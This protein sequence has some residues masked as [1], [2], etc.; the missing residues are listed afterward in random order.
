M[1]DPITPIDLTQRPVT[2][3]DESLQPDQSLSPIEGE[4]R[5]EGGE[6]PILQPI[7]Q[8]QVSEQLQQ[9][10]DQ[11][12]MG[13]LQELAERIEA[14]LTEYLLN[15]QP[16][17]H[18]SVEGN[19]AELQ[20]GVQQHGAQLTAQG[21]ALQVTGPVEEALLDALSRL[22]ERQVPRFL[23]MLGDSNSSEGVERVLAGLFRQLTGAP[24]ARSETARQAAVL[25]RGRGEPRP[26]ASPP[27]R[28]PTQDRGMTGEEGVLYRRGDGGVTLDEDYGGHVRRAMHAARPLDTESSVSLRR[29]DAVTG[30][31]LQMAEQFARTVLAQNPLP[32]R[33]VLPYTSEERLGLELSLLWLEAETAAAQPGVSPQMALLLRQA[34]EQRTH[35]LLYEAG[36]AFQQAARAYPPAACPDLRL[37]D[38]LSVQGYL[39]RHYR[40][41]RDPERS[42]L[43]TI[44]YTLELLESKQ[45]DGRYLSWLRYAPGRGLFT[46]RAGR[47]D[48]KT[49]WRR[50]CQSWE[51]FLQ[52][53]G[54]QHAPALREAAGLHS[55]WAMVLPPD[56]GGSSQRL[57][58]PHTVA[59]WLSG[60]AAAAAAVCG[61][62]YADAPPL[63]LSAFAAAL[64]F[65][66]TA[67][68]FLHRDRK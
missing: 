52:T 57:P 35:E 50:F 51:W 39:I 44:G 55:L 37:E 30:R 17:A 28:T 31:D 60:A 49:G 8:D 3:L 61:L 68:F 41:T 45:A 56:P 13:A 29:G 11:W 7:V 14:Q 15:W 38:I 47:E 66:G 46:D 58:T 54:F 20:Q 33:K 10:I 23:S 67:F 32:N 64:L 24:P 59:G 2:G 53:M 36:R 22:L 5:L 16:N 34:A 6:N 18:K 65:S 19:L 1:L 63:R 43:E 40:I 62:W 9:L 27:V 48:L 21:T 4:N 25:L 12:S 42:L 26:S